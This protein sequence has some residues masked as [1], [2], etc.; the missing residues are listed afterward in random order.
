[1]TNEEMIDEI[2]T[3]MKKE[4]EDLD[5]CFDAATENSVRYACSW[6]ADWKDMETEKTNNLKSEKQKEAT[7]ENI[8]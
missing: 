7:D 2:I 1:M 4:A 8:S 3:T 6:I 5:F